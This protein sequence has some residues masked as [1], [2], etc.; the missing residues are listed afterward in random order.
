MR[1]HA[2]PPSSPSVFIV[3]GES[4]LMVDP[5]LIVCVIVCMGNFVEIAEHG[6][7]VW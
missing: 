1:S 6:R 2:C 3:S 7:L 5:Y 4:G